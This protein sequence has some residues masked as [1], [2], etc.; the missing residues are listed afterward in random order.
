MSL[1]V[2]VL[3]AGDGGRFRSAVPKPLHAAAGRPLLWHVLAAAAELH[4]DRTVL[5]VGRGADEVCAAASSLGLGP[6]EFAVQ[7]EPRGTGD[8]LAWALP[9]LG[10]GG[11]VLVLHGDTPLLTAR[12]L[13]RLL[14]EH[15]AAGAVATVLTPSG[16]R[17]PIE[18]A[19]GGAYLF[20]RSA[21]D[22]RS[23]N[24]SDDDGGEGGEGGHDLRELIPGLRAGGGRVV[25]T[26][27]SD[28]E[29]LAVTDRARL[30]EAAAA[31]R[32]R[33]LDRLLA[34]GV[35]VTDPATTYVDVD[36]EVGQ[37]TV[38]EPL[39]FLEAGTR[40]GA[41]CVIGPN[42]RLHA[43]TVDDH[44]TVTQT[45]GVEAHV[46][47]RATVGPFAY[48]R[49][50][51]DLG[52][53]SK[54]GTYVEVKKSS[55]GRGS[56]VPHLTYVGDAEI[57]EDVNVGAGTVFVNYDGRAK[58]RT[59]VGNGAFIG[60]DTML[61]A[62]L[63][64]GDGAQTAAGSTITR[65]VPAGALAIERAVQRIIDGWAQRR[66]RHGRHGGQTRRAT[67]DHEES[68]GSGSLGGG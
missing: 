62:P 64:I 37:D 58:H 60:S 30:A 55:V 18:E 38:L 67:S 2:V 29:L 17:R 36:V 25:T 3:A 27:A 53:G 57:G 35:T 46:G 19:G 7:P 31:L 61:V 23:R 32:R 5:V 43:C 6:L 24:A 26:E 47:E 56:K 14:D 52:P 44:A 45:V 15:Q 39:T 16:E 42:T 51:A 63:V 22:G 4:A 28:G 8:A 49:P 65:D 12:T 41:G 50:G 34:D 13:R 1:S 66:G 9:R 68:E 20:Q 40:I 21:L 48:L 59:V 54:V 33:R 11:E 10:D